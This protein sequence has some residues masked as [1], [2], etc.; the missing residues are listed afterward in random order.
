[1]SDPHGTQPYPDVRTLN[2]E[3]QFRLAADPRTPLALLRDLAQ[4]QPA[5]R[6]LI[7]HNPAAYPELLQWLASLGDPALTAATS[8]RLQHRT[9]APPVA[10]L[11]TT[12]TPPPGW[13]QQP[14][15]RPAGQP[16]P[17]RR[18]LL[19]A[20]VAIAAVLAVVAGV[21]V[22]RT[23][24]ARSP[25]RSPPPRSSP[26]SPSARSPSGRRWPPTAPSTSPTGPTTPCR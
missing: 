25:P 14:T 8:Q 5:A 22:Y 6:M 1:M 4:H 18:G 20:I 12:A 2:A 26:P 15:G 16:K 23:I 7:A 17:R 11:T 3:Q 21:F 19:W 10:R 24:T 13:P 9:P